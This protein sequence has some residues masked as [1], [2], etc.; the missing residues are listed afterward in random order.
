MAL[1]ETVVRATRPVAGSLNV[2][3]VFYTGMSVAAIAPVIAGFGR[4]Y[5]FRSFTGAPT[6]TLLVN[7]HAA[8]LTAW[9]VLLVVQTSL[10]ANGRTAVHRRLGILGMWLGG[11]I[12]VMG[13]ATAIA[14]A[15]RGYNFPA[16]GLPDSFA[17]LVIPLRDLLVF[18]V[19]L[20]LAFYYRRTA[21]THKRLMLLATVGG[22]LPAALTRLPFGQPVGPVVLFVLFLLAGPAFDRWSRGRV[23][24]VYRWAS[25]PVFLSVPLSVVVGGTHWWRAFAGWLA[26]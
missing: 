16:P 5:Y 12:L 23:H 8:V 25:A 19:L 15:R 10:V 9:M 6:P 1:S 20:A 11:G 18:S 14:A 21:E 4:T 7:A 22:L 13:Y 26:Q 24:T 17:F 3:R 2:D